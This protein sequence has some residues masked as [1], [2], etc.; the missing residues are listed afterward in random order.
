[1]WCGG[2]EMRVMLGIENLSCVMYL[3]ILLLGSWLFLSGFV[4]CVILIW[5]MLVLIK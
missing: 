4:F 5:I 3:L 1:M 2:G